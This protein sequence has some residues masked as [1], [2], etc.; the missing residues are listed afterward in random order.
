MV[1]L[2]SAPSTM[3]FGGGARTTNEG[4]SDLFRVD[5]RNVVALV[6]CNENRDGSNPIA[7]CSGLPQ[8]PQGTQLRGTPQ[9]GYT[10]CF[11]YKSILKSCSSNPDNLNQKDLYLLTKHVRVKTRG[12]YGPG[13]C[14]FVRFF[15]GNNVVP[16][17][18]LLPFIVKFICHMSDSRVSHAVMASPITGVSK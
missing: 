15:K 10:L 16:Q 11:S 2:P 17:I 6:G 18:A 4:N 5:R 14:R 12:A 9:D 8:L 3:C 7:M 13:W 1:V